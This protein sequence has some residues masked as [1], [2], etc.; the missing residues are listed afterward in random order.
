VGQN[1]VYVEDNLE[2]SSYFISPSRNLTNMLLCMKQ[3]VAILEQYTVESN[4]FN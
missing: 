1:I 4:F 3:S 2:K